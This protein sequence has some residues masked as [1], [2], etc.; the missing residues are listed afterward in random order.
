MAKMKDK[1]NK[2]LAV[3]FVGVLMGALDI[4]IVGPAIPSIEKTIDIPDKSLGWIFSIFVLFNLVG[5]PLFS[6]LSDV[7]GRR[8]IYIISLI[9]FGIGS[10]VVSVSNDMSILLAGRAIQGFGASGIFPVASAVVGDIFPPEKRGRVLGMIGAVFGFAFI[11]GPLIAGLLL[12]SFSWHS[13]FL[14]NIPIAIVLCFAAWKLLPSNQIEEAKTFDWKG[15]LLLG[16][17]LFTFTFG[18]NNITPANFFGSFINSNV[19]PFIIISAISLVIL[20]LVERKAKFPI[21]KLQLFFSRQVT[22]V[23]FIA[24]GIGFVQAF[25]VFIPNMLISINNVT[26]SK[27]SFMLLPLV[28]ATAIGSPVSGIF[29]DKF[30]SKTVVISGLLFIALGFGMMAIN[31]QSLLNYY[32]TASIAGFGLSFLS[33]PSL[34][35]IMLNEVAAHDRAI[36]QGMLTIFISIGQIIGSAVISSITSEYN[37]SILGYKYSLFFLAGLILIFIIFAFWLKNKKLETATSIK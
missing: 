10:L 13:L 18:I 16:I 2:I 3:L 31:I 30:G 1:N 8:S 27:A 23:A 34:R 11:I 7:F 17:V 36:T 35:Y 15:V 5:I 32:V 25:I 14:I 22:L 29:L 21:V 28:I 9:T 6:K 37:K 20:I 33:G 24:F 26:E 12:S 4:S 19:F